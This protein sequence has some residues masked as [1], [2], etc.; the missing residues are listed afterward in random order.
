MDR[1]FKHK[2]ENLINV[3]EIVTLHY[4]EF[5]KNFCFPGESHDFWELVFASRNGIYY[6]SGENKGFLGEG[7]AVFHKPNDFHELKA[8]GINAPNVVIISFQ[9]KS[10]SMRFFENKKISLDD[11]EK[12]L[13]IHIIEEG[14][15]TFD[16]PFSD[17][18]TKKMEQLHSPTLGGGQL[19]KNY[20]E[21]FLINAVRKRTETEKGNSVFLNENEFESRAV[22]DIIT[23]LNDNVFNRITIDDVSAYIN[24]SKSYI[25]K[26]FKKRT[27]RTP[28]EYFYYLKIEKA[29]FLLK[30]TSLSVKEVSEKLCFDTPNYFTKFFKKNVGLTPKQYRTKHFK[31]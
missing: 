11:F 9:C 6:T 8:D 19:I 20:L 30:T 23:Y 4:F 31:G 18:E 16:I 17:P 10:K 2:L 28:M 3:S 15:K 7:E 24:Y 14:K 1:Y 29:M 5:D 27:G 13:L 21:L 25:F 22:K 12:K 26:E